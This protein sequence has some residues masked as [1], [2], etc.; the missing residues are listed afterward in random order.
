MANVAPS[1]LDA[2]F[3]RL[4]EEVA[5]TESAGANRIHVD[6]MDGHFVPNLAMGPEVVRGLRPKTKLPLE[7]H[8]MCEKPGDFIESFAKAGADSFIV[9]QEVLP[10]PLPLLEK[11][12]SLGAKPCMVVNPATPVDTLEPYLPHIELALCMTVVPGFSGQSFLDGS[13]ERI[14][15]LRELIDKHNPNC[16]LEV[17]GGVNFETAPLARD[18]GAN[19]F[20]CAS[21]VFRHPK[22]PATAVREMIQLLDNGA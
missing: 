5:A 15:R 4:G 17:D 11:I 3:S 14:R 12:R 9:H 19:V 10:D 7:V 6:V 2:D 21:A 16:E 20:V 1:I 13:V 22:G 18:A 8:L